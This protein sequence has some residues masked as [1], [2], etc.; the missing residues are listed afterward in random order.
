MGHLGHLSP[1]IRPREVCEV[2]DRKTV[3]AEG[4]GGVVWALSSGYDM[5]IVIMNTIGMIACMGAA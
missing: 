3:G 5:A 2:D 1:P 4:W